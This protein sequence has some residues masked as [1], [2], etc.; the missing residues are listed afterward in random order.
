MFSVSWN[1]DQTATEPDIQVPDSLV[2]MG[3]SCC[4]GECEQFH[5]NKELN[6]VATVLAVTDCL[7][8]G[9]PHA[10]EVHIISFYSS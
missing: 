8:A 2:S 3:L 6:M 5:M 10:P 1:A 7:I 9:K 4:D